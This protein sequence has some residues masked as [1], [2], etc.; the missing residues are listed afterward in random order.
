MS[1]SNRFSSEAI[2]FIYFF[3]CRLIQKPARLSII[4]ST[5]ELRGED[6]NVRLSCNTYVYF[7]AW[8][9]FWYEIKII[10]LDC[11]SYVV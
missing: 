4:E 5:L 2:H 7:L 10:V 3:W 8:F 6:L 9:F 1:Q 11:V